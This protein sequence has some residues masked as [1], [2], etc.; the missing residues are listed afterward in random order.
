MRTVLLVVVALAVLALT[1]PFQ[2]CGDNDNSVAPPCCPACGDG[3]CSGDEGPCNCAID[4]NQ[5]SMVCTQVVHTCGDGVCGAN[6]ES[7]ESCPEDCPLD[8]RRCGA[9]EVHA[10]NHAFRGDAC[11]PGTTEAYR[12]GR[13]L[14]CDSCVDDRDCAN[15]ETCVTHC[16]PGCENDTGGCCPQRECFPRL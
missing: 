8:C 15:G 13:F 2:G 4:C 1:L 3:V 7:H 9:F 14:V 12:D 11:P 6:G 5:P 10:R 16:G